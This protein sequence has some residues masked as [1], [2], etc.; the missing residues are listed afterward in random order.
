ME[1]VETSIPTTEAQTKQ[2]ILLIVDISGYT[3]FMVSN[4]MDIAH[5]QWVISQ[6]IK[7]IINQ[8][9]IPLEIAKLEGDAVFLYAIQEGDETTAAEIGRAI[10]RKLL[11]FFA[12][13]SEKVAEL[14]QSNT[15]D[16]NACNQA[17][18]L[19]LK[20]IVHSGE[21]LFYQVDKFFELAGPDVIIVHRLLKNSVAADEYILFTETAYRELKIGETFAVT[22][23][24]EL[25]DDINELTTYVHFPHITETYLS[26]A[27][28]TRAYT[29]TFHQIRTSINR[30]TNLLL[31]DWGLK[32]RPELRDLPDHRPQMKGRGWDLALL[33]TIL[34]VALGLVVITG[35]IRLAFPMDAETLVAAYTDPRQGYIS[36]FFTAKI[37]EAFGLP[38]GLF[39]KMLGGMEI[40]TGIL[41]IHG[42]IGTQMTASM[43]AVMFWLFTIANPVVGQI[44]LSRDIALAGI[45]IAVALTGPDAWSIDGKF[46]RLEA[47]LLI[48]RLS[49][50]YPLIVSALFSG[51]VFD[52]PLNIT[53]PTSLVLLLGL[54][55][56]LGLFPRWTML[57][58]L[59][60]L[61][62]I[63]GDS[64]VNNG[65]YWGLNEVKREIGLLAAALVYFVT[66]PDRWAWPK[67]RGKQVG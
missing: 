16:C 45:S 1:A 21:A 18:R 32:K 26:K 9:E 64:L 22:Q 61:L 8:V 35:G 58:M 51:G 50:A 38:I 14:S 63:M 42:G 52:N 60:W 17:A 43:I 31:M 53:L 34:R 2:V 12:A 49:L 5:S 40:M 13:F 29:S 54:S 25:I 36:P 48:L 55:F 27:V 6:I 41:L 11:K 15:C 57:L 62:Y 30:Q 44:R 28:E 56:G 67:V 37:T 59:L 10:R 7:T 66:G 19:R 46:K 3:R 39:L 47:V 20:L 65:I 33:L 4:R 24:R 23:N